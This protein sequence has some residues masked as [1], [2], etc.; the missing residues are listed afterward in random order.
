[1]AEGVGSWA[2]RPKLLV[3]GEAEDGPHDQRE[4]EPIHSWEHGKRFPQRPDGDLTAHFP[5]DQVAVGLEP[6]AVQ[7]ERLRA[8]RC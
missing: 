8:M 5:F 1:V 6:L 4:R 3:G 7:V 2:K